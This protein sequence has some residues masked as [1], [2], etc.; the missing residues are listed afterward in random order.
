VTWL[1]AA[2]GAVPLTF[3]TAHVVALAVHPAEGDGRGSVLLGHL[4]VAAAAGAALRLAGLRG[5]L[6]AVTG[7]ASRAARAGVRRL[8]ARPG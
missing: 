1:P 8:L 7:A 6:E 2:V 5:P 3:Y 4:A